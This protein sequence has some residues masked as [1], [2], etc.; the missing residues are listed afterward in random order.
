MAKYISLHFFTNAII[1]LHARQPLKKAAKNP[2]I[3]ELTG[4]EGDIDVCIASS[5]EGTTR[6][7]KSR[8]AAPSIGGMT[9]MN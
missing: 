5:E 1:H 6:S 2:T 8:R 4:I 7:F 9:I 3:I